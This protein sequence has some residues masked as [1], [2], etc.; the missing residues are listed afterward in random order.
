MPKTDPEQTAR[1]DAGQVPGP[2][3]P[4]RQ[5]YLFGVLRPGLRRS[6]RLAW[7]QTL[8]VPVPLS[9]RRSLNAWMTVH[10]ATT[11]ACLGGLAQLGLPPTWALAGMAAAAAWAG[12]LWALFRIHLSL[13]RSPSGTVRQNLG[14]PN[15]LTTFRLVFAPALFVLLAGLGQLGQAALPVLVALWALGLTDSLDGLL[16][17]RTGSMTLFGR[18]LDPTA[19]IVTSSA[20]AGGLLLLGAIPWWL[21]GL[22]FLRY[23]GA[24]VGLVLV[25]GLGRTVTVRSTRLGKVATP[26]VQIYF[27]VA[28]YATLARQHLAPRIQVLSGRVLAL[29]AGLVA[30]I[31]ILGVLDLT[32]LALR[33]QEATPPE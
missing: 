23:L 29:L 24:L 6:L 20:A 7:R 10:L 4:A 32:R 13:V 3:A 27:L 11:L 28:A 2:S 26:T 5:C 9:L 8:H 33:T 19:D 31:V 17:R 25:L 18:D 30:A 12:L 21:A 22:V 1:N 14:L 15:A 16:A